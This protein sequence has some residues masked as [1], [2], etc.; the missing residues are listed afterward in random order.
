MQD[1]DSEGRIKFS[2]TPILDIHGNPSI[3]IRK[4]NS[5]ATIDTT[6]YFENGNKFVG[7]WNY[8]NLNGFGQYIWEGIGSYK[9]N[10]LDGKKHGYGTMIWIDGSKYEG[11]WTFDEFNGYGTYPLNSSKAHFPSYLEPSI[12][13]IVPY[14]CF[15]P[16]NQFPL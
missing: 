4:K 10:W 8:G 15:F 14:P 7:N 2:H 11:G 1:S 9:G 13:I 3:P 5:I 6:L 12:Q 16:S